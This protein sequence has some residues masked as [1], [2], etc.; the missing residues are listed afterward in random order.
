MKII[1]SISGI[2]IVGALLWLGIAPNLRAEQILPNIERSITPQSSSF[3][4]VA[5]LIEASADIKAGNFLAAL[6]K[7]DRAIGINPNLEN[8][9][10][11]RGLSNYNLGKYQNAVADYDRAIK[12]KPN[13]PES[14]HWRGLAVHRL[15]NKSQTIA[16]LKKAASLYKQKGNEIQYQLVLKALNKVK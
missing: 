11:L 13:E 2:S 3:R 4:V 12:I 16:D 14:Y 8:S 10:Y 15:G 1:Y 5:L 6:E 9:Y 7:C